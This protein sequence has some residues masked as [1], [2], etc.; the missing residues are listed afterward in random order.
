[1]VFFSAAAYGRAKSLVRVRGRYSENRNDG[2]EPITPSIRVSD[3]DPSRSKARYR[4][5]QLRAEVVR[6]QVLQVDAEHHEGRRIGFFTRAH[7]KALVTGRADDLPGDALVTVETRQHRKVL[8]DGAH[9]ERLVHVTGK[10]PPDEGD[11]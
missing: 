4:R 11:I 6:R 5:R 10:G 9:V 2:S 7:Q 1:M 8:F 3:P